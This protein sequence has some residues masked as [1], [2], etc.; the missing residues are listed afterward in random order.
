MSS[1]EL[2]QVIYKKNT[3]LFY[4]EKSIKIFK[5]IQNTSPKWTQRKLEKPV[6]RAAQRIR[7]TADG[8]TDRA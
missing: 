2:T 6:E 8:R 1:A 3:L 5:R 7:G 4:N